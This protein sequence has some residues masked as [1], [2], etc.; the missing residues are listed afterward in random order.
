MRHRILLIA[1]IGGTVLALG[2][3][4]PGPQSFDGEWSGTATFGSPQ[5]LQAEFE[6]TDN[7]VTGTVRYYGGYPY[8]GY[9]AWC[10]IDELALDYLTM[11][12]YF[13]SD[14]IFITGNWDVTAMLSADGMTITGTMLIVGNGSTGTFELTRQ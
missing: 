1:V 14:D 13:Y 7:D 3:C 4:R 10:T 2:A 12:G 8:W 6:Q 11:D 5:A 9:E